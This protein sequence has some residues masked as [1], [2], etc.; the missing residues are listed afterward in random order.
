VPSAVHQSQW[1]AQIALCSDPEPLVGQ[2]GAIRFDPAPLPPLLHWCIHDLRGV[3]EAASGLDMDDDPSQSVFLAGTLQPGQMQRFELQVPLRACIR[4][5]NFK[6][7]CGSRL[8]ALDACPERRYAR[9]VELVNVRG[10]S[11]HAHHQ[12]EGRSGD[13]LSGARGKRP[14]VGAQLNLQRWSGRQP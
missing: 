13:Q 10:A 9:A 8:S 1:L 7:R 4:R 12:R 6:G 5:V 11:S 3:G 14:I 2:D